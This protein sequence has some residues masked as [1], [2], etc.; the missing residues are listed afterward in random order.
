[1]PGVSMPDMTTTAWQTSQ[2]EEA[3][4]QVIREGR[5]TM[6]AFGERL[7]PAAISQLVG[8]VRRFTPGAER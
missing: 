1:M 4:A 5:G 3:I 8:H 6:P 2:T 7:A